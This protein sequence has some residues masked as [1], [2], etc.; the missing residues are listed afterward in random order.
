MHPFVE[1]G[2]V[3]A[4][5]STTTSTIAARPPYD[6]LSSETTPPRLVARPVVGGGFKSY[7]ANGRAFMRSELLTSPDSHGSLRVILRI[8]AGVDF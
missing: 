4:T 2:G 3:F 5:A 6:T 7:F 8:G 1:T